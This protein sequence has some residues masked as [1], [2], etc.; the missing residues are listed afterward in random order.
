MPTFVERVR[1]WQQEAGIDAMHTTL[2]GFSQGAIMA[3]ESTQRSDEASLAGRVIAMAGRFAQP[4]RQA[5]KDTAVHLMH[6]E[7]DQVMPI[8]LA[9]EAERQLAALGARPSLDRFPGLGH[10]IDHRVIEAIGL[11]MRAA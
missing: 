6:G 1:A 3:L 10:G 11:R 2:I 8:Q 5:P 7:Q 4:P 9:E